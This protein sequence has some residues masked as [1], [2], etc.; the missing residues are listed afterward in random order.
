VAS[1]V[2]QAQTGNQPAR[3]PEFKPG[4]VLV[5]LKPS[6]VGARLSRE[7]PGIATIQRVGR[8]LHRL[9]LQPDETVES[10][11]ARLQD[12]PMVAHAQPNYIK[13]LQTLDPD[14]DRQWGL[15]NEGQTGG[16]S[17]AD[18][19]AE[20]AWAITRGDPT[21]VVAVLDTGIAGG[22]ASPHKD[23]VNNLWRNT[24]EIPGDGF[25][26]DN[27]G[28]IDDVIGCD[29]SVL[30][31]D[32]Q[33]I[34]AGD[35]I[36]LA[37]DAHGT[38]VAGVIAAQA[39]NDIGISGISP[40]VSLMI[41]KAFDGVSSTTANVVAAIE[42]AI[43]MGADVINA[44]YGAQGTPNNNPGF[45]ALEYGAYQRAGYAGILVVV[46]AGNGSSKTVTGATMGFD[47]DNPPFDWSPIVPASY[48]LAN[49]I[50]VAATDHNDNLASFS[51][52]G[53]SSVDLAAPGVDI[54]ST[55]TGDS[56]LASKG[57]SLAAPFVT[58]VVALMLSAHKDLSMLDI[59]E[60]LLNSVDDV[61][62]LR[63]K[64]ASGGRLNA[65]RALAASTGISNGRQQPVV[66][67]GG[68]SGSGLVLILLA[69]AIGCRLRVSC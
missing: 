40:R 15:K 17:G 37:S 63:S 52:Y 49:I 44:S 16:N 42:Y 28:C 35:P 62:D 7:I 47:N 2:A 6:V 10:M 21:V 12:N 33:V 55:Y 61:P 26:N 14:Y 64:V 18:V 59:K 60:R 30:D 11:L 29:L 24:G 27:N 8:N 25:D 9:R 19:S 54:Y 13:H 69:G 4:E 34:S 58:G 3:L 68:G 66:G 38:Q 48:D 1:A 41:V 67:G 53:S 56:Y 23:L 5:T 22:V 45:D 57:T 36:D 46:P 65:A 32:G 39:D 51:N 20:Q 43:A 50:A 31:G